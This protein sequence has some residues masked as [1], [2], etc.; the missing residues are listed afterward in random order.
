MDGPLVTIVAS[1]VCASSSSHR[2]EPGGA[3]RQEAGFCRENYKLRVTLNTGFSR[4]CFC[5]MI[6]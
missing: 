2:E 1:A 5:Q 6:S 4:A 3:A